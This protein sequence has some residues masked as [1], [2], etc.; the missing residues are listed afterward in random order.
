MKIVP[1]IRTERFEK[2]EPGELFLF[3]E[4]DYQFYAL[5]T[6]QP[7]SGDRSQFVV[8]GPTFPERFTEAFLLPWA[9]T[10]ALSFGKEYS[11]LLP[12][13]AA[14]WSSNGP[15]REPVCL[16]IAEDKPY[17]CVNGGPSPSNF[18][19]C[20]VDM[21]TGAIIERNLPGHPVFTNTWEIAI[22]QDH[23]RPRSIVKYPLQ[24]ETP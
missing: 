1:P 4:H 5:K 2:L 23:Q 10:T 3:M 16:A 13:N 17:V 9:A 24:S 14:S 12:T 19:Q 8:L 15:N 22:S 6:Q 18:F 21:E 20:F 7:S 11:I